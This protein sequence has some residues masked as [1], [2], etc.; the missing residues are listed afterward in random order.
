MSNGR[1]RVSLSAG[2]IEVEGTEAFV[3]KYDETINIILQRLREG[4]TPP[5]PAPSPQPQP[6]GE[7]KVKSLDGFGEALHGFANAATDTDKML[8]A[9]SFAQGASADNAFAT[10]AASELLIE[11]GV[12]PSNP[13]QCMTNNLKAKRVIKVGKKYRVSKVGEAHLQKLGG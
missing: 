2:E 8:L 12:K 3:A 6:G 5:G 1:I 10:K 4:K 7:Q 9:G 13:S 11:Q